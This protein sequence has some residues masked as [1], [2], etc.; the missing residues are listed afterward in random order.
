V[1]IELS[2]CRTLPSQRAQGFFNEFHSPRLH[3]RRRAGPERNARQ[4]GF[5]VVSYLR[6]PQA[7]A[8]GGGMRQDHYLSDKQWEYK[9]KA[10]SKYLCFNPEEGRL[11]YGLHSVAD[12]F[13]LILGWKGRENR[14]EFV[15]VL[16]SQ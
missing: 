12:L 15:D 4:F 1:R 8:A 7:T 11:A 13:G 10:L 14:H 16:E 9:R 2:G 6:I 5:A 3:G